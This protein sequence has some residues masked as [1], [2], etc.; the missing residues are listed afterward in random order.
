M[1]VKLALTGGGL[2]RASDIATTSTSRRC[3]EN[4]RTRNGVS[5]LASFCHR[6]GSE[7]AR[8]ALTLTHPGALR[9]KGLRK[10][11]AGTYRSGMLPADDVEEPEAERDA[12]TWR[13]IMQGGEDVTMVMNDMIKIVSAMNAAY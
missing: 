8:A 9:R 5:K 11:C 2:L 4:V 6:H 3:D 12:E 7:P 13:Q 1:T 10:V